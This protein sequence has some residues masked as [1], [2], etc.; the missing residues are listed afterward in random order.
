MKQSK[1]Q[2]K[3][4]VRRL[5]RVNDRIKNDMFINSVIQGGT[6]IFREIK[7]FRGKSL[8]CSSRIDNEGGAKTIA[9]HFAGIFS[10]L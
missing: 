10:E 2:Y 9:N 3:Y 1:S 4:A 5:K 6:N 8:T 7:K